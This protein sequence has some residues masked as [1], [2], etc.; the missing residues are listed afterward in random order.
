MTAGSNDRV[1]VVLLGVGPTIHNPQE[2]AFVVLP[3][4]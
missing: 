3:N 4:T 2:S 1:I